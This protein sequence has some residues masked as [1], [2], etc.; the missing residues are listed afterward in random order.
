M[1]KMILLKVSFGFYLSQDLRFHLNYGNS[2]E[3]LL[4]CFSKT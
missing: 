3:E 1:G 2:G 4:C